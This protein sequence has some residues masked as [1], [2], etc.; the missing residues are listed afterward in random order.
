MSDQIAAYLAARRRCGT[1]SG[2]HLSREPL[3]VNMAAV[4]AWLDEHPSDGKLCRCECCQD[5]AQELNAW[6]DGLFGYLGEPIPLNERMA[7]VEREQERRD[8]ET[9]R[10]AAQPGRKLLETRYTTPDGVEHLSI[11]AGWDVPPYKPTRVQTPPGR[12]RTQP[13]PSCE[14]SEDPGGVDEESTPV[15]AAEEAAPA[16]VGKAEP[17]PGRPPLDPPKPFEESRRPPPKPPEPEKRDP[18]ILS[19]AGYPRSRDPLYVPVGP[20]RRIFL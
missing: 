19:P 8:A 20:P 15:D 4:A 17:A 12:A 11:S 1:C 18:R 14:D 13:E 5:A 10:L 2:G 16:G 6:L 7:K 9:R 3:P